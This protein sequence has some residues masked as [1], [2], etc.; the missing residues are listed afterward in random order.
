MSWYRDPQLFINCRGSDRKYFI[1]RIVK[2]YNVPLSQGDNTG[3]ENLDFSKHLFLGDNKESDYDAF[4]SSLAEIVNPI[5]KF[6][7]CLGF[8]VT[9]DETKKIGTW[10]R[11]EENDS[12]FYSLPGVI[13]P[14]ATASLEKKIS[15]LEDENLV[16]KEKLNQEKKA[17][18]AL[19]TQVSELTAKLEECRGAGSGSEDVQPWM[20]GDSVP[21]HWLHFQDLD[22]LTFPKNTPPVAIME[23]P[24]KPKFVEDAT[25]L[26]CTWSR[27]EELNTIISSLPGIVNHSDTIFEEK[28]DAE[29]T[30]SELVAE[31]SVLVA[32]N[33][34]LKEQLNHEKNEKQALQTQV[35]EL[36]KM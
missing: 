31:I 32:E 2:M 34:M 18:Q 22:V 29:K 11:V 6:V 5:T 13:N 7:N 35:L 9:W 26:F 10:S 15:E 33:L 20:I 1:D 19:E 17:K 14:H 36:L 16:L 23:E 3:P 8:V 24:S 12:I 27:D 28:Q 4:K 21:N 25:I 30:N